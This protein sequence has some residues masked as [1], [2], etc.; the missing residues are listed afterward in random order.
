MSLNRKVTTLSTPVINLM[1]EQILHELANYSIYMNF[2][3]ELSLLGYASGEEY[4]YMRAQEEKKH[5]EILM[6]YMNQ[7]DAPVKIKD[8]SVPQYEINE[9]IDIFKFTVEREIFTTEKLN[10]IYEAALENKDYAFITWLGNGLLKI[11]VED[12]ETE[13]RMALNIMQGDDTILV[14]LEAVRDLLGE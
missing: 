11:Q 8:I 2:S 12:E 4:Y 3:S 9:I 6:E 7:N 1:N 10:S 5:A 13:S 14:K